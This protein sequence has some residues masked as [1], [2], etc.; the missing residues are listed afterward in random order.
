MNMKKSFLLLTLSAI[1]FVTT[2]QGKEIKKFIQPGI[3]YGEEGELYTGTDRGTSEDGMQYETRYKNGQANGKAKFIMPNGDYINVTFVDGKAEGKLQK[4]Y[5]SGKLY[6]DFYYKDGLMEG[7]QKSYYENGKLKSLRHY[8]QGYENGISKEFYDT[9]VLQ[10]EAS[11]NDGELD[12]WRKT[13]HANKQLKEQVFYVKD[14]Q[15]GPMAG[16]DENGKLAYEAEWKNGAIIGTFKEYYPDGKLLSE[17]PYENGQRN[18]IAVM[19]DEQGRKI[20]EV[21]YVNGEEKGVWKEFYEDGTL[22]AEISVKGEKRHG[23]E[24]RYYPN[25]K[26][27]SEFYYRDDKVEGTL[28]EYDEQGN[29]TAKA[30]AL[31]GYVVEEEEN[32]QQALERK[33]LYTAGIT[34][35]SVILGILSALLFF[36]KWGKKIMCLA[37]FLSMIPSYA[38]AI[39]ILSD[40]QLEYILS[41]DA[42]L[43]QNEDKTPYT[44]TVRKKISQGF[45]SIPYQEG[46]ISGVIRVDYYDGSYIENEIYKGKDNG[47]M[48][49]YYPD[50]TLKF[51]CLFKDDKC[52]TSEKHYYETGELKEVNFGSQ[53]CCRSKRRLGHN[54]LSE[55][56][57]RK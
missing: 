10:E 28:K 12:G 15:E 17:T 18:G 53:L 52:Q 27:K 33:R 9:G 50:G 40:A 55:R 8:H 42:P 20:R 6:N 44:G 47:Y 19:Y 7:E 1:G 38:S 30:I 21:P 36:K 51:S 43:K 2:V 3:A 46:F 5:A 45:I 25:G 49:G 24:K 34:L 13:Y 26:I 14:K 31:S 29:L 54:L 35:A 57:G 4:F 41:E 11:L 37:L 22:A 56:S 16:Y 32:P 39:D 23:P 48:R